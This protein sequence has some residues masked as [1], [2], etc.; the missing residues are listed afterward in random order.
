M[1]KE[2]RRETHRRTQTDMD[3]DWTR[4]TEDLGCGNADPQKW[5]RDIGGW[6]KVRLDRC[7]HTR[8][9]DGYL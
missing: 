9:G 2:E 8:I 4:D 7:W 3:K 1:I 5:I 6:S